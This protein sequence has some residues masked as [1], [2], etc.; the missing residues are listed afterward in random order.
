MF[1]SSSF[2]LASSSLA[3]R[4][5]CV[6][7]PV[8]PRAAWPPSTSYL[9]LFISLKAFVFRSSSGGCQPWHWLPPAAFAS[10]GARAGTRGKLAMAS[11]ST[12]PL[13]SSCHLTWAV[14]PCQP[15]RAASGFQSGIRLVPNHW[16]SLHCAHGSCSSKKSSSSCESYFLAATSASWPCLFRSVLQPTLARSSSETEV[17][18]HPASWVERSFS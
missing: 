14:S 9:P 10:L 2:S 1:K 6:S 18:G 7:V 11:S 12:D 16:W 15:S 17:A 8:A 5:A 3:T 13:S 4:C